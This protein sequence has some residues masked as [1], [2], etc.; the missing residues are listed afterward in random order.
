MKK[1]N[2]FK[3][4]R[5]LLLI[6]M[7]LFSGCGL[8]EWPWETWLHRNPNLHLFLKKEGGY[9]LFKPVCSPNGKIYYIQQGYFSSQVSGLMRINADGSGDT[10]LLEGHFRHLT[11]SRDGSKLVVIPT[12]CSSFISPEEV[13]IH[14]KEYPILLTSEGTIIDT[15]F[16]SQ[17]KVLYAEF[18]WNDL[19]LYCYAYGD[20]SNMDKWGFYKVNLLSH[21]ETFIKRMD[22]DSVGC[23]G[24]FLSPADSIVVGYYYGKVN[25]VYS[26]YII[27]VDGP[28]NY[29]G[30]RTYNWEGGLLLISK[31]TTIIINVS[32]YKYSALAFPDWSSDGKDV[33]FSGGNCAGDPMRLQ[34]YE[35]WILK[36][37]IEK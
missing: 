7:F 33:I 18:G 14:A 36:D 17:S 8:I 13:D 29:E 5:V 12:S 9:S 4:M 22:I 10:L 16:F 23:G 2:L 27:E 30:G 25:P 31:D 34:T 28:V 11:M 35:L 32:P 6:F 15:I 24:F 19:Y 26:D 1:I 21:E 20:S 37:V 3:K